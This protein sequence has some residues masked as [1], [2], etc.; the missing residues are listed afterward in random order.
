MVR[1]LGFLIVRRV[2][3]ILGLG[4]SPDAQDVEIAVLRHQIG[5]LNPQV[6]RTRFTASDRLVLATLSRA[7]PRDRW[8]IFL[9][10]PATLLRWHREL[11]ARK[12]THPH[13][14]KRPTL[15]EETVNLVIRLAQENPRW[16]LPADRRRSPQD[17]RAGLG[18]V[19]ALDPATARSGTGTHSQHERPVLGGVHYNGARPHRGLHLE[20]P[21]PPPPARC[22]DVEDDD[23]EDIERIDI[24][25][26]L[27]HEYR[28]AA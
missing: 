21:A 11:I 6:T 24:L 22:Q 15:P 28:R 3:G 13:T 20:I 2:L 17:R 4:R 12:W 10:T 1:T 26:G 23:G 7:L 19:G 27:I 16:G 25:G 5:V 14:G 8:A 9:L 18:V